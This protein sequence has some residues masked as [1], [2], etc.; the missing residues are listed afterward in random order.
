MK[1]VNGEEVLIRVQF[2]LS[3]KA[4]FTHF[5]PISYIV[6]DLLLVSTAETISAGDGLLSKY[7]VWTDLESDSAS[8]IRYTLN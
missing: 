7:R 1:D 6:T 2:Y 4:D 8:V 3:E 5:P